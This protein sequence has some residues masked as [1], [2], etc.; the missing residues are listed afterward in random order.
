MFRPKKHP[1]VSGKPLVTSYCFLSVFPRSELSIMGDF[2]P[3]AT[4]GMDEGLI[5]GDVPSSDAA[6][7]KYTED[8]ADRTPSILFPFC[9]LCFNHALHSFRA[10]FDESAGYGSGAY[11]VKK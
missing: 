6:P 2:N 9:F 11:E 3:F 4:G 8:Y 1:L 7:P 5:A 10:A